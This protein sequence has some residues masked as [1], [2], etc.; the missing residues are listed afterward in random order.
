V[1]QFCTS[2]ERNACEP[3]PAAAGNFLP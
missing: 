2:N 1:T 3:A